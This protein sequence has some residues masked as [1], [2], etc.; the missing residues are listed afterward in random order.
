MA[1][2]LVKESG[3]ETNYNQTTIVPKERS[4][5]T[6]FP[7]SFSFQP[8]STSGYEEAK[9]SDDLLV[10]TVISTDANVDEL[11]F[12]PTS[13]AKTE[14]SIDSFVMPPI[15]SRIVKIRFI[16]HLKPKPELYQE[17]WE[18]LPTDFED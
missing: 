14:D 12:F 5:S 18:E 6:F 17:E 3:R 13:I 15:R 16:K 11:F 1:A 4:Q 8:E 9:Q 2:T 7:P 10:T